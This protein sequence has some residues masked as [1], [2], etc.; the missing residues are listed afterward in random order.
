MIINC[1]SNKEKVE[2]VIYSVPDMI[3]TNYRHYIYKNGKKSLFARIEEAR[4]YEKKSEINCY[5]VYV[6]TYNSKGELT[7]K[8][9][10]ENGLINR[11]EKIF[12]FSGNVEIESIEDEST[13]HSQEVEL[14]YKNNKLVSKKDILIDKKDGS[15]IKATSMESDIKLQ[16]TKFTDMVIKY[17]YD[18]DKEKKD[19]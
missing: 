19:E 15:Y 18:E 11:N 17:Y 5:R 10:S 9:R 8:I 14:D 7:T 16:S 3:Q 6:E 2:K 1:S 12:I 13:L 4:F